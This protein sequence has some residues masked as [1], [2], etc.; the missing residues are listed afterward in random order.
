MSKEP[1]TDAVLTE[2]LVNGPRPVWV[3]LSDYDPR[4][5]ARFEKRAAELRAI[6]GDRARL[7]EH[8]GSTS[9]PGLA[10]KPIIDIVVGIDDP[11]DE[12]AYLPDLQVAGYDLHVREPR[13][14]CL[15]GGDPEEP[16]NLHCY[17]P[18]HPETHKYLIFR[19]HLRS[20]ENDRLLYESTKRSLAGREWPDVNYYAQAKQPVTDEILR[21]AGWSN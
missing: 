18:D 13:H 5:P 14:R 21:R 2:L 17:P 16:N 11:D 12:P 8:I 9:V 4:W 7:I 3:E 19:D 1:L 15:R 20:D 10:A 6:L